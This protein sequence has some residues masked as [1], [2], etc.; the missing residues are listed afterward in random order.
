MVECT[1][2]SFRRLSVHD[3]V[4]MCTN[5]SLIA[6]RQPDGSYLARGKIKGV[7]VSGTLGGAKAPVGDWHVV[8]RLE[9]DSNALATIAYGHVPLACETKEKGSQCENCAAPIFWASGAWWASDGTRSEQ[10]VCRAT[11]EQKANPLAVVKAPEFLYELRAFVGTTLDANARAAADYARPREHAAA[12]LN[13]PLSAPAYGV[14]M[15]ALLNPL[16]PEVFGKAMRDG[17]TQMLPPHVTL[18]EAMASMGYVPKAT[19]TPLAAY[20]SAIRLAQTRGDENQTIVDE[21]REL[22][23]ENSRLRRKVEKLERRK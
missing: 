13:Q 5:C 7:N 9:F 14:D 11:P 22:E 15:S 18:D 8:G 4:F 1:H 23:A 2:P 12:C 6:D 19:S 17:L 20:E 10:A 16:T 3:E 21:K